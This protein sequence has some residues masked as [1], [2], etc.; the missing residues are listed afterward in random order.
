M[1]PCNCRS[2]EDSA[3]SDGTILP[4]GHPP[5]ARP[6]TQ[7]NSMSTATPIP[8]ANAGSGWGTHRVNTLGRRYYSGLLRCMLSQVRRPSGILWTRSHADL[9]TRSGA[10]PHPPSP[11]QRYSAELPALRPG[12]YD[13]VGPGPAV[14]SGLLPPSH[15]RDIITTPVLRVPHSIACCAGVNR[16]PPY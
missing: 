9:A 6:P 16:G 10:V 13:T 12:V 5:P 14:T 15:T 4:V 7:A 8:W 11:G 1:G 2:H 3:R